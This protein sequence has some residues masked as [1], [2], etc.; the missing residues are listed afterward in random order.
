M[1]VGQTVYGFLS[2]SASLL[3]EG[4]HNIGDAFVLATTV[5]ILASSQVVKARLALLKALLM[6]SFGLPKFAILKLQEKAFACVSNK[7]PII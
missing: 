1:F 7:I 3:G 5:Y 2:H 4:A 6:F